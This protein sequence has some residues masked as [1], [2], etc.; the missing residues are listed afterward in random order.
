MMNAIA[1][2]AR[3]RVHRRITG[4]QRYAHEIVSRLTRKQDGL[5][6]RTPIDLL[7]PASAKGAV[8]HLW[9]QTVL[10]VACRGRLLW[11]PIASGPAFY[12]RHVVTFHDLFPIEHPEW[13][14]VAYA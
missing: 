12:R 8:G 6:E 3:Y 1:V 5:S 4:V 11:S 9:E 14:S 7:S 13:Y 2:N 10:P